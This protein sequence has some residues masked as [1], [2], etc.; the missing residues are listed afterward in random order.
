MVSQSLIILGEFP[1]PMAE[2]ATVWERLAAQIVEHGR[3]NGS[4]WGME[5]LRGA[6]GSILYM[7]RASEFLVVA[8]SGKLFRGKGAGCLAGSRA[9]VLVPHYPGLKPV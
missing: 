4:T 5:R 3:R 8:P 9:G 2:K 7:G 6:D 1:G